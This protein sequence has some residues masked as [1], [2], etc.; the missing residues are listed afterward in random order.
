MRGAVVSAEAVIRKALAGEVGE[1]VPADLIEALREAGYSIVGP[2]E[3][4]SGSAP[5][6][7]RVRVEVDGDVLSRV[8]MFPPH[9]DAER[10]RPVA[11]RLIGE[12]VLQELGDRLGLLCES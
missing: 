4:E 1:R 3:W 6:A 5:A 11:R 2:V 8:H 9:A 12:H 7:E 10:V